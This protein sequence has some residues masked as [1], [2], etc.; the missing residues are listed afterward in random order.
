MNSFLKTK[1][2]LSQNEINKQLNCL[3]DLKGS[4]KTIPVKK[5][6]S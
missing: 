2:K 4:T 3:R 5:K 1:S 6:Q